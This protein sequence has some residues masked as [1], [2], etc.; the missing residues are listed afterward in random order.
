MKGRTMHRKITVLIATL[1]A[2][3]ALGSTGAFASGESAAKRAG[4]Y[5]QTTLKVDP[6]TLEAL[7]S[8]GVSPG[9]VPPGTLNGTK[10]A[11]PITNSPT[12]V[13]RTGVVRHRGG[14][15][16]SAG[17]TR[18]RLTDFGIR[19]LDR[20]LYG[21]VNGAGP[22]ALLDLDYS[23]ARVRLRGTRVHVGGIGSTLTAGAA[24]ALNDAFG[25]SALSDETRIGKVS[26][27]YRLRSR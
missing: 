9:A 15:S 8:L 19:L 11:F 16:L 17:D 25:T 13:L 1:T 5:G 27:D 6:A 24:D 23:K 10:Y 3:F 18:V 21:K 12:S 14:I 7:T 20:E 26:V 4:P 2:M 22:V